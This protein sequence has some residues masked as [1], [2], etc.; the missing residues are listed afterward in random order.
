MRQ[1]TVVDS[2]SGMML[3]YAC[4]Y[5]Q[6]LLVFRCVFNFSKL[7]QRVAEILLMTYIKTTFTSNYWGSLKDLSTSLKKTNLF[8]KYSFVSIVN[9]LVRNS[10]T[11][12]DPICLRK[13]AP[14][15]SFSKNL[16]RNYLIICVLSKFVY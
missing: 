2:S 10:T 1:L 4:N 12:L 8:S 5:L 3:K 15:T 9:S 13:F 11:D 7:S 6:G 14:C 16:E